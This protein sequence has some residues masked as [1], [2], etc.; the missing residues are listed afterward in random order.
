VPLVACP[1]CSTNL[2]VP[3]GS[4]AAV[5]CPKCQTIFQPP[6]ASKPAF[7]VVDESAPAPKPA[8]RPAPK[9]APRADEFEVVDAT[10]TKSKQ[11][12]LSLDDEED[13]RRRRDEDEDDD[14]RPRRRR[15][16]D[17]YDDEDDRPR[18]RRRSRDDDDDDE[19]DD[20]RRRRR[21]PRDD[22]DDD[23]DDR[24]SRRK[25]GFGPAKVGALLLSISLWMYLGVFGI[26]ALFVLV[27]WADGDLPEALATIT[28][29]IGLGNWIVGAVGIGF[30]L[31]GPKRARGV[32]IAAAVLAGVQLLLMIVCYTKASDGFGRRGFGLSSGSMLLFTSL[33]PIL[34]LMLPAMI[35]ESKIFGPGSKLTGELVIPALAGGCE[36]A[37]LVL[38]LLSLKAM[39]QAAGNHAAAEKA[40]F[41]VLIAA[42]VCG[43]AA[44]LALLVIVIGVE[45]KMGRGGKHLLLG[46]AFLIFLGYTLMLLPGALAALQT[47]DALARRAR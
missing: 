11:K 35:Y 10:P 40:Q 37:R 44:V 47:R 39:A 38:V 17:D 18:G 30:C 22:Y 3:D 25:A 24:P 28:G 32:T 4:T 33:I 23:Y 16:D 41:G 43:V 29:L 6:K 46:T 21:R 45:A 9:P 5:R 20:R 8:P 36:I 13:G 2:R 19:E 12:A 42:V 26:L 34:D 7:E 27:A 15:R 14:D 31:A 1:K